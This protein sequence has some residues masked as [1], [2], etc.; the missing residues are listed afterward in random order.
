MAVVS[1]FSRGAEGQRVHI[2]LAQQY[3][4]SLAE[5]GGDGAILRWHVGVVD[6]GA[7]GCAH[8]GSVEQV[9]E[10]DWNAVQWAPVVAAPY[11][12]LGAPGGGAGLFRNQRYE[13]I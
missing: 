12:L 13:G 8:A 1:V 10:A 9:F 7:R 3:R 2:E 4:A 11:V 5:P 6:T